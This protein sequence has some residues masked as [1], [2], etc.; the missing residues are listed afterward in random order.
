MEKTSIKGEETPRIYTPPL[1]DLTPE[2]SV[3]F[4][5]IEFAHDILHVA[6]FPWQKWLMIHAFEVIGDDEDWKFRFRTVI[7]EAGRQN[8]KT[9]IGCV[10]AL[11]FLYQLQVSLILGTAQ[12]IT[13]AEDTWQAC[14]DMAQNNEELS[15]AIEHI[16]YS[17]GSKR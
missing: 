10:I 2:T 17:S 7:V 14:V 9:T 15:E 8:G 16:W 13:N 6:L 5:I 3:G 4:E 1:R 12:D 11:F